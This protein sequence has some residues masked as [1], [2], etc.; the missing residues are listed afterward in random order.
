MGGLSP[1][2]SEFGA[3]FVQVRLIN[4]TGQRLSISCLSE[5]RDKHW[6]LNFVRFIKMFVGYDAGPTR[7]LG[8]TAR[9]GLDL[10]KSLASP[11]E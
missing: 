10:W 8:A 5:G 11:I 1:K 7:D 9:L 6:L 3:V 4:G 2:L